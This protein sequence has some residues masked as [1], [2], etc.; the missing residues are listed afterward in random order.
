MMFGPEEAT[1]YR[2]GAIIRSSEWKRAENLSPPLT[3]SSTA[4]SEPLSFVM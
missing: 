2:G 4:S 1:I 3:V